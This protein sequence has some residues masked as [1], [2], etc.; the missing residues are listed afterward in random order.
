[1]STPTPTPASVRVNDAGA[2]APHDVC[3]ITTIHPDFD[4][5]V[6]R[7]IVALADAGLDVCVIAP[8]D[9][10]RRNRDDFAFLA[11]VPPRSRPA[12]LLH[13]LRT[14]QAAR[15]IRARVYVFHDPDFL[16]FAP[17]LKALTGRPVVYDCHEN[18]PE[19]IRY[20][21]EWI[22]V[23]L[24]A[25]V[26]H[27]YRA[28][29]NFIVSRLKT[30]IVTVP[31]LEKRFT[32]LGADAVLVRNYPRFDVASDFV[33][34]RAVL[35]T[36]SMSRDY[37]AA[38]LLAIAAEMKRRG[39]T[40]PLRV[41]DLFHGDEEFRRAFIERIGSAE[42]NIE[43]LA[44]VPSDRMPEV[45]AKGC[46]GLS[47]IMDLPN[48]ALA[49]PTKIFEYFKFG[50][51]VISSDV[52]GSRIATEDGSL[53]I[54]LPHDDHQRWVDAIERLLT[55][56]AYYEGLRTAAKAAA[57]DRFNWTAEQKKLVSYIRDLATR[58]G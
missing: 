12:R 8:W 31:H 44:P 40:V 43:I 49:L 29:E 14:F 19:D 55:D 34:D 23:A 15:R 28:F 47:P 13:S 10:S 39:L 6:Y 24:R 30:T 3:V 42:L 5:R 37:G 7:Q 17:V 41:V 1:M 16:P 35:Y 20:G 27:A 52:E 33:N 57:E 2:G 26:S 21:K 48:K 45:L 54:L 58:H 36:G 56:T 9:F 18:L 4:K 38:N 11:T 22:P 46:I 25:P 32:A 51:V 50:L 53:G